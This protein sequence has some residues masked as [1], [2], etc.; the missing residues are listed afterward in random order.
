MPPEATA[1]G[2][3]VLGTDPPDGE[4][5]VDRA[6]PYGIYF[7]RQVYP[8]DVH[9]GNVFVQSGARTA[10]VSAWAEPVERAVHVELIGAPLDPDVRHRLVVEDLRDWQGAA[11]SEPYTAAFETG[12]AAEGRPVRR[13]GWAEVAPILSEC[14]WCH[15]GEAPVLGLDLGSPEGIR[16]TAVGVTAQQTRVG[17]QE[18]APLHGSPTMAGMAVIDV[19]GGVGRPARS[20][21]VQKLLAEDHG[22]APGRDRVLLLSLWIRNGAP[23]E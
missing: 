7:D 14:A 12:A 19:L 3:R 4:V 1:D 23:T 6:G 21:L 17:L 11:M 20:Y 2:P 8:R 16:E 18:E 13:V 22:G 10:F 15:G 9:R 5:G